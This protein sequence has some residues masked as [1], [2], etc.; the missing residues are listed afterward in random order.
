[1][2]GVDERRAVDTWMYRLLLLAGLVMSLGGRPELGLVL[3]A[4]NYWGCRMTWESKR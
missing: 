3:M 2:R 1:M 4:V